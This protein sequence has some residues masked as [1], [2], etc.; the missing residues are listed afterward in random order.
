MSEHWSKP[1]AIK[2]AEI[3]EIEQRI[4]Q[5]REAARRRKAYADEQWAD[6]FEKQF[7]YRPNTVRS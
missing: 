6:K 4:A 5:N 7:G 1:K 3:A 2:E